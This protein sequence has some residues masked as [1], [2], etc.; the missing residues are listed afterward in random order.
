MMAIKEQERSTM[1]QR[2]T[3]YAHI[4]GV[5]GFVGIFATMRQRQLKQKLDCYALAVALMHPIESK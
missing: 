3:K 5:I 2:R 1:L 4:V